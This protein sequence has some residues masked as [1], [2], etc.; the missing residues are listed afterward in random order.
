M[1]SKIYSISFSWAERTKK[2]F[3]IWCSAGIFLFCEQWSSRLE[4]LRSLFQ[5]SLVEK[6]IPRVSQGA[7]HWICVRSLSICTCREDSRKFP[8]ALLPH[9]C[10][11]SSSFREM[12]KPRL[13]CFPRVCGVQKQ[14]IRSPSSQYTGF[15]LCFIIYAFPLFLLASHIKP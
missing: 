7:L 8:G 1:T 5:V 4:Y 15:W 9:L 2:C 3:C 12:E 13:T 10:P 6:K 14:L 11:M